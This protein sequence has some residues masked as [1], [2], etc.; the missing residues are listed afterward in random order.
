MT[1]ILQPVADDSEPGIH[2]L[3]VGVD[4]YPYL[5]A[6]DGLPTELGDGFDVLDAPSYSS[7]LLARRFADGDLLRLPDLEVK[8]IDV[9]SSRGTVPV[10]NSRIKPENP[11]F[12]NVR[13]AIERWYELGQQ[14][15]DNLLIFYFCGHGVQHSARRHSLLCGDFGSHK[16]SPFDHAIDYEGFESGMRSC[17]ARRQIFLI[18]TCRTS[19]SELTNRF[20]GTGSGVVARRA[21]V[22]LTN[23]AQSVIWATAGGAQAWAPDREPSVFADA[24]LRCLRGGGAE[25]DYKTGGMV[26]TAASIQ[27]A[28]TQYLWAVTDADQEPQ[29]EQP[30]GKAF[31]LHEYGNELHVPVVVR[32]NP[33]AHTPGAS[34]SCLKDG[35][36]V[37]KRRPYPVIRA[38][39]WVLE[40]PQGDY[41]FR[42]VSSADRQYQGEI[43]G[44]PLPPLAL[45]RIPIVRK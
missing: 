8:S 35:V 7:N 39:R 4:N 20:S 11:S 22:D 36:T 17:A 25:L 40:L 10:L 5:H 19:A 12:E 16:L 42:A 34:L 1:Y 37:K 23:V 2:I 29:T 21:P 44:K 31:N 45:V 41:T 32:C 43:A 3:L 13:R 9:L 38:D 26:A 15:E 14:S 28:M 30:I 18:D 27:R 24:F 33:E 6:K